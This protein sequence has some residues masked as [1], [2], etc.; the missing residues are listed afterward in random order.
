MVVD[1][2]KSTLHWQHRCRHWFHEWR[3]LVFADTPSY[4]DRRAVNPY[5]LPS[6]QSKHII[7]INFS[8]VCLFLIKPQSYQGSNSKRFQE[9][10]N[11]AANSN[12]TGILT[13]VLVIIRLT[14]TKLILTLC[15]PSHYYY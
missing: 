13:I 9:I 4:D 15:F 1:E 14:L 8:I 3:R 6:I 10:Y 5:T 7:L 11:E 12:R 2:I